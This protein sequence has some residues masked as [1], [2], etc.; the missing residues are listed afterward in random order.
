LSCLLSILSSCPIP[1]LSTCP[2]NLSCQP[3]LSC[4][5]FPLSLVLDQILNQL[6]DDWNKKSSLSNNLW[7]PHMPQTHQLLFHPLL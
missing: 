3:V 1:V 7:E 5:Q 6:P 4:H 2:V